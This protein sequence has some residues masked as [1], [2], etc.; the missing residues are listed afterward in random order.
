LEQNKL[1]LRILL[2]QW[3]DTPQRLTQTYLSKL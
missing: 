2:I 1:L 3:Q